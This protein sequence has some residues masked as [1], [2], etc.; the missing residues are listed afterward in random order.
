M[1]RITQEE[2]AR[3]VGPRIL[4]NTVISAADDF[5]PYCGSYSNFYDSDGNEL[6]GEELD[7][8][9]RGE[10]EGE[11]NEEYA[12]IYQYFIITEDGAEYLSRFTDDLVLYSGKLDMY[13]WCIEFWGTPWSGVDRKIKTWEEVYGN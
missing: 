6:V 12:E 4:N 13:L 11:V 8:F 7:A 5:E 9:F 3:R 2:L 10:Y 1:E